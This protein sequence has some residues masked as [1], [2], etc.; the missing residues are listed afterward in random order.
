MRPPR[1][2]R[3]HAPANALAAR[4]ACLALACASILATACERD[5][6]RPESADP[7][8]SRSSDAAHRGTADAPAS[9]ADPAGATPAGAASTD[10]PP[11]ATSASPSGSPGSTPTPDAAA[12]DFGD[13]YAVFEGMSGRIR[14]RLHVREAPRTCANFVNLVRR[15]YFIGRAWDDFSPVVRQL[16]PAASPNQLPYV[17]PREP[18]PKLLFDVGGRLA[19]AN[20]S[21][22]PGSRVH[23]VRIFLTT[24]PQ[25]RWNL[26]YVVFGTVVEG[27]DVV[28]KLVLTEPVAKL[29]IEGDPSALLEAYATQVAEWNRLLDER[30]IPEPPPASR[31]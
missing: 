7:Q 18:S 22:E 24:K 16:G 29:T 17:L 27:L 23:P 4:F 1:R 30:P 19:A 25:E 12:R 28:Q 3:S 14:I 26:E 15:G 5:G 20:A 21:K 8:A 13:L 31:R 6:A 10:A 2:A 11:S 9:G